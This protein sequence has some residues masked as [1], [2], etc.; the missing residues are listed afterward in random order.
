M[1]PTWQ[2]LIIAY[3]YNVLLIL[4]RIFLCHV[5][6]CWY[7]QLTH[8]VHYVTFCHILTILHGSQPCLVYWPA[9][10]LGL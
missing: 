8:F 9:V 5:V 2:C 7:N 6:M 10:E 1:Y 4:I 3:N